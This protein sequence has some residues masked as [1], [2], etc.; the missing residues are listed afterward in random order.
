M[1]GFIAAIVLSCSSDADCVLHTRCTCECC[2]EPEA[3]TKAEADADRRR[4]A[5]GECARPCKA[6]CR[7]PPDTVAACREAKCVAMPR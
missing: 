5:V 6:K 1:L 7:K 4:C 2:P 3:M